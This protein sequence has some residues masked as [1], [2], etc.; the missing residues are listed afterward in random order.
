MRPI[1]ALNALPTD[2]FAEALKPLFETASPLANA[3]YAERP[4]GSYAAVIDRA[5]AIASSLPEPQQ[6]AVVN[7]HPRI[8]ESAARMSPISAREQGASSEADDELAHLNA[9]YEARHG[10][11]FVVFVN[12]RPRSVIREVLRERL[13]NPREQ[14]LRTALRE[15]F[16][17]ARDRLKTLS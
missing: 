15:M 2:A 7:A 12:R 8:G 10:F 13:P 9:A 4:F 16:A 6:I 11:R 1:E 17:I 5:E 3:L 14:E